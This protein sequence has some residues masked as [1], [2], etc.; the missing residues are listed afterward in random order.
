MKKNIHKE[1]ET[2]YLKTETAKKIEFFLSFVLTIMVVSMLIMFVVNSMLFTGYNGLDN[3]EKILFKKDNIVLNIVG[4]ILLCIIYYV[5]Y[6]LIN[7]V[8]K[9]IGINIVIGVIMVFSLFIGIYWIRHIYS[10][11]M[12][13]S[14]SICEAA[15]NIRNG[16]YSDFIKNGYMSIYPHQL[17]MLTLMRVIFKFFGLN[18]W[19]VFQYLNAFAVP[20][21]ILSGTKITYEITKSRRAEIIALLMLFLFSP[22]YFYTSYTYN[23][24]LSLALMLMSTW[25]ILIFIRKPKIIIGIFAIMFMSVAVL[26]RHNS[27][28]ALIAAV[29]ILT[30]VAITRKKWENICLAAGM[31][32]VC[33]ITIWGNSKIYEKY[34]TPDAFALPKTAYVAMGQLES[35]L[36]PGWY[37]M[38]FIHVILKSQGDVEKERELIHNDIIY[39]SKYFLEHPKYTLNFYTRKI[40]SQ[41]NVPLYQGIAMNNCFEKPY[42]GA[43]KLMYS[44][45]I[46][47]KSVEEYCNIFHLAVMIMTLIYIIILTA[48]KKGIEKY[49]LYVAVLGGFLFSILWEAKARYVFPYFVMLI[50]YTSAGLECI[51]IKIE[52]FISNMVKS[53]ETAR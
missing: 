24:E 2:T 7:V 5:L 20:F 39:R 47:R 38:Y 15:V 27:F 35:E 19:Y 25:C 14:Y 22:L 53:K 4:F 3:N 49:I 8:V 21:I 43:V 33:S 10:K 32:F 29:I 28:I 41:W 26:L 23:D 6:K 30:I 9:K 18:N 16:N 17:G 12:A 37:G 31:I 44:D 13:D 45:T 46:L 48:N 34:Y 40:N 52:T 50:P 42:E 51:Y 11:P 1:V 36:G